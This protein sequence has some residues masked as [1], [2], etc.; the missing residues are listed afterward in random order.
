MR[1]MKL[2]KKVAIS[3]FAGIVPGGVALLFGAIP[4]RHLPEWFL[5]GTVFGL[6]IGLPC[7]LMAPWISARVAKFAMATRITAMLAWFLLAAVGGCALATGLLNAVGLLGNEGFMAAYAWALRLSLVVT[8]TVGVVTWTVVSLQVAL[9]EA[10]EK[11]HLGQLA[12]ERANKMAVEARIASLESRIHPHFLFNTLN[13]ISALVR[14]DPAQAERMIERL[15]ALLRASLDSEN[16]GLVTVAE[17]LR[18]VRDYLEIE[19]VRFGKRLRYRIEAEPAA[20]QLS[21]PALS[22]QTL[23]ENSVKYAVGVRP[24]GAE[25]VITALI[26]EGRLR[27]EVADDGPGFPAQA[28]PKP[29][30]GID[31]LQRRLNALFGSTAALE[32]AARDGRTLV[33]ISVLNPVAA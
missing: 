30:H 26:R 16:A 3:T 10:R 8:F 24:A 13:S 1:E 7:Q 17:E 21:V 18:V 20:E 27:V 9:T 32:I 23:A 11:L 22:I 14:E 6:C 12:E 15:A 33:A 2:G 5:S 29:G 19:Q 28:E 25:I 4:L 31:L